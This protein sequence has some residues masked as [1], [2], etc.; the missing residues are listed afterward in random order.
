MNGVTPDEALSSEGE[1]ANSPGGKR[2]EWP[3]TIVSTSIP[4]NC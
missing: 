2:K 3:C 4:E 1:R